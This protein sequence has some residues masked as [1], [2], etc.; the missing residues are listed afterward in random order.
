MTRLLVCCRMASSEERRGGLSAATVTSYAP[1]VGLPLPSYKRSFFAAAALA[2]AEDPPTVSGTEESMFARLYTD[3]LEA[4]P[5]SSDVRKKCLHHMSMLRIAQ[6]QRSPEFDTKQW[7]DFSSDDYSVPDNLDQLVGPNA[8]RSK[9]LGMALAYKHLLTL[10]RG[11]LL[12]AKG[13]GEVDSGKWAEMDGKLGWK[14][15]KLQEDTE[16]LRALDS[17]LA[18]GSSAAAASAVAASPS[19]RTPRPLFADGGST[20]SSDVWLAAADALGLDS[21]P[22]VDTVSSARAFSAANA[23]AAAE[24]QEEAEEEAEWWRHYV[25]VEAEMDYFFGLE[26]RE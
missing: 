13:E 24:E 10:V 11:K 22:P 15:E 18:T 23:V 2:A 7:V 25:D 16:R 19:P 17:L 14:Q 26:R 9:A 1:W 21:A 20:S 4:Q 5:L 6:R 8:S 12:Y 3:W